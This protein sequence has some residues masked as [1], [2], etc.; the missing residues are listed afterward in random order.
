MK[1]QKSGNYSKALRVITIQDIGLTAVFAF[2]AV[3]LGVLPALAY[4]AL[5]AT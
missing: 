5:M 4:H 3:V 1:L 2:W